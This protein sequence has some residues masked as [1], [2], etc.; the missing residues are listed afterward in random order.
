MLNCPCQCISCRGGRCVECR[1][2]VFHRTLP[3]EIKLLY[4]LWQN[5]GFIPAHLDVEIVMALQPWTHQLKAL[6]D[7]RERQ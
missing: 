5:A 6:G 4:R 3:D 2:V 1:S 7:V